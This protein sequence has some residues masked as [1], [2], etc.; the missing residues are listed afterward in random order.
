MSQGHLQWWISCPT[1]RRLLTDILKVINS[2]LPSH[3]Q[4]FSRSLTYLY[5][6]VD[7]DEYIC[8]SEVSVKY[9]RFCGVKVGHTISCLTALQHNIL[10]QGLFSTGLIICFKVT[11]E[12]CK[13]FYV[14]F[15]VTSIKVVYVLA[16]W[17]FY[18][19]LIKAAKL[20]T[21]P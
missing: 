10:L 11:G 15:S 6:V 5:K 12:F 2:P 17:D 21:S 8:T 4:I 20:N 14:R 19:S 16:S 18:K 9:C 13:F 1:F 3:W 7:S